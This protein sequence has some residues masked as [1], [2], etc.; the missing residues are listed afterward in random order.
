[1]Q[2]AHAFL[3]EKL[4]AGNPARRKIAAGSIAVIFVIA[5]SIALA[6]FMSLGTAKSLMPFY[7]ALAKKIKSKIN[8]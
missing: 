5:S 3:T 7:S 2:T 8:R 6:F 4:F 1:M